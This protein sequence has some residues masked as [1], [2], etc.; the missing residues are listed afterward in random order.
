MKC[1]ASHERRVGR[2]THRALSTGS[3]ASEVSWDVYETTARRG[4]QQ[5]AWDRREKKFPFF[6][7]NGA[8]PPRGR[9]PCRANALRSR[10]C[11]RRKVQPKPCFNAP[12]DWTGLVGRD[13]EGLSEA[14]EATRWHPKG[15]LR[16]ASRWLGRVTW[17]C[18]ENSEPN[19]SNPS[20]CTSTRLPLGNHAGT[21]CS[22]T[23]TLDALK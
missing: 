23:G 9:A 10:T 14:A 16:P 5:A 13:P 18:Q 8:S 11:W 21:G 4:V 6:V 7:S 15:P 3:G 22:S 19:S 12:E 20:P 17:H 2:E 1:C